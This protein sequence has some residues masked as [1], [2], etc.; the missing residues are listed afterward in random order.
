M[1]RRPYSRLST[2]D[3]NRLFLRSKQDATVVRS[4]FD[5]LENRR[6]RGA[7]DLKRRVTSHVAAMVSGRQAGAELASSEKPSQ[8]TLLE[9]RP[10]IDEPNPPAASAPLDASTPRRMRP[11]ALL[12]LISLAGA[13]ALAAW[14]ASG[15]SPDSKAPSAIFDDTDAQLIVRQAASAAAAA[16]RE[17]EVLRRA[18]S[19]ERSRVVQTDGERDLNQTT[20]KT[21]EQQ[22]QAAEAKSQ[23]LNAALKAAQEAR[24][25]GLAI[26]ADRRKRAGSN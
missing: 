12:V 9:V 21:L 13:G 1:A 11:I 7:V 3:L 4:I 25:R 10:R 26:E 2:A 20:I 8:Q 18:L 15:P 24:T 6:S 14:I 23:G 17:V 22:L 5:E 19:A 16:V